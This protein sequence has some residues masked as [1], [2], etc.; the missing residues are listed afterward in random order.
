[1]SRSRVPLPVLPVPRAGV[2]A[3]ARRRRPAG[4][5]WLIAAVALLIAGLAQAVAPVAPGRA[6]A[7]SLVQVTGFGSNPGDLLMYEYVPDGL[8]AGAPLVVALHGCTQTAAHYYNAAGWP[9]YA[10]LWRFALV[11]PQQQIANNVERCFNWF[12]PDDYRR[13]Q[14]EALSIRQMVDSMRARH[15]I[16][17]S[18]VYVTGVS[19]GG[20]MTADMLAAY[21]DV[22]AGGGII[23][24][25][26]YACAT[27][28]VSGLSC[29]LGAQDKT[30]R[31]WGDLVRDANPGWTGPWP[32][33]AIW[34]GSLDVAVNPVNATEARDQWTD[35]WGIGQDPSSTV[36]LPGNGRGDTIETSYNDASARPAVKLYQVQGMGHGNPVDPGG[37]I[38]QCGTTELFYPSFIC[39]TYHTAR[40][41]G[42]DAGGAST[43]TAPAA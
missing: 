17:T 38:H 33:V 31:Q 43:T 25:V 11:F 14:G 1:M 21:P 4:R 39:S 5:R 28:V 34:H 12:Q 2:S 16:D 37:A 13:G 3:R 35:V 36:T 20:A 8:P 23:A 30:P 42:L 24:A 22:F 29:A 40:F 6:A 15:G 26:P 7:A 19:A 10:E 9:K 41:W 32:R 27:D 18:Q